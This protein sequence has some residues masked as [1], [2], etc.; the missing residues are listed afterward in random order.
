MFRHTALFLSLFAVLLFLAVPPMLAQ[1]GEEKPLEEKPIAEK[2]A[3]DGALS[4]DQKIYVP[5]KNLKDVFEKE[6]QGVFV[7]FE[8]FLR[9]WEGNLDR[10]PVPEKPPVPYLVTRARYE[11]AIEVE[12]AGEGY[13]KAVSIR[14]FRALD[15]ELT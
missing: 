10:R 13:E 4:G 2:P 5:F 1:D 14:F 7:P 6:G 9:L 3:P 11:G 12:R 15:G 8:E